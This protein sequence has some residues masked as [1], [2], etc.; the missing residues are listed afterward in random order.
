MNLTKAIVAMITMRIF[1]D[2]MEKKTHKYQSHGDY[3]SAGQSQYE[4]DHSTACGYV[5]DEA[6]RAGS[7][8]TCKL[9]LRKI[10]KTNNAELTGRGAPEAGNEPRR[11]PRSG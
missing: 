5:R 8:V 11:P 1:G 7:E 10:A 3:R 2:D 9:C 6:T 4:Y